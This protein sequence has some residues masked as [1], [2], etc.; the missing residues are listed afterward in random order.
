MA[1][2]LPIVA[3]LDFLDQAEI[4][5]EV[6]DGVATVKCFNVEHASQLRDQVSPQSA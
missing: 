3:M 2:M 6:L 1:E 5:Q 4:E